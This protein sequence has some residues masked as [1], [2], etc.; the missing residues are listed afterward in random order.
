MYLVDANVILRY[1]T[2]DDK[3]K[4]DACEKLLERAV[5]GKEKLF[6]S[7]MVIA[8]II[9]VLEKIYKYEKDAIR[10]RIEKILNTPNLIFQN[11]NLLEESISLY[12]EANIDFIDAYHIILMRENNI[13]EIYSYDTDFDRVPQIKRKEP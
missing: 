11:K 4:A 7:D 8:E 9:W 12:E 10:F 6:I 5:D 1:L 3:K 2:E 13:E